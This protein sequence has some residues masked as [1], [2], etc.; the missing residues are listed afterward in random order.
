MGADVRKRNERGTP[1]FIECKFGELTRTIALPGLYDSVATKTLAD[2]VLTVTV[3]RKP[4]HEQL[5]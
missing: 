1:S 5:S 4:T 3:G 2:G